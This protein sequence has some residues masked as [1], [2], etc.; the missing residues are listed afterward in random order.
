MRARAGVAAGKFL[1]RSS[2][3]G[4]AATHIRACQVAGCPAH[5]R[6]CTHTHTRSS[7]A[8][9]LIHLQASARWAPRWGK[10]ANPASHLAGHKAFVEAC[11]L[12]DG[13]GSSATGGP[14]TLQ[15]CIQ[16]VVHSVL[17][18]Q[19]LSRGRGTLAAAHN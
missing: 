9:G 18:C 19:M 14:C 5:L 8:R 12:A 4:H 6:A 7:A 1:Q 15:W 11:L 2:P 10:G 3:Q 17:M 16:M 13:L